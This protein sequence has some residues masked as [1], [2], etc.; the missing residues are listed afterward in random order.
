MSYP[1]NVY[2][3]FDGS[4][5]EDLADQLS[6]TDG[7]GSNAVPRV[8]NVMVEDSTTGQRSEGDADS[9][10]RQASEERRLKLPAERGD[11]IASSAHPRGGD[12]LGRESDIRPFAPPTTA[13]HLASHMYS[14]SSAP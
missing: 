9:N 12:Y 1:D 8:P 4:D 14:Q 10:A 11:S 3:V 5:A 2:S 7:F 13:R 6:P